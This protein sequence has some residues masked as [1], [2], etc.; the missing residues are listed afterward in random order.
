MTL[1]AVGKISNSA[2]I[3]NGMVTIPEI[4]TRTIEGVVYETTLMYWVAPAPCIVTTAKMYLSGNPTGSGGICRAQIMKNS[5]LETA[6]I[7]Q[8][9]LAMQITD[10]SLPT[11]GIYSA[12]GTLDPDQVTL[13]AGDVLWFRVNQAD[14][15]SSDLMLQ[16]KVNFI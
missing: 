4:V 12:S 11:N 10:V 9:D 5:L 15:G 16:T 13:A 2:D 7:F 8:Y 6:S 3:I 1:S 14:T